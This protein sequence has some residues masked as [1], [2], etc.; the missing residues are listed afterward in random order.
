M[1]LLF[2][3]S[4]NGRIL[5]LIV[6]KAGDWRFLANI[7]RI[8]DSTGILTPLRWTA[9]RGEKN[10]LFD[11]HSLACH[12]VKMPGMVPTYQEMGIHF[13]RFKRTALRGQSHNRCCRVSCKSPQRAQH[14]WSAILAIRAACW[15]QMPPDTKEGPQGRCIKA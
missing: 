6:Q 8:F 15:V 7:E 12:G 14:A 3:F 5:W 4:K 11:C 1:L 13:V 10:I 9:L 2:D